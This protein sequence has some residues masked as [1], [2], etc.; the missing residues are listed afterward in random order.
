MSRLAGVTARLRDPLPDEDPPTLTRYPAWARPIQAVFDFMG[1]KAG[2]RE[3]DAGHLII[4]FF[5]VFSALLINDGGYGLL[6]LTGLLLAYRPLTRAGGA[7]IVNLGLYVAAATALFGSVTGAFFGLQFNSL[8]SFDFIKFDTQDM[9]KISFALGIAHL[10]LGRG[11]AVFRQFPNT[12]ALGEAGWLAIIWGVYLAIVNV[13]TASPVPAVAMPLIAAGAASVVAFSYNEKGRFFRNRLFGLGMLAGNAT[14]VFSDVMSYI[15]L[16]A[17]GFAS[18]SLAM[19]TNTI[20]EQIG[21]PVFGVPILI[22][23]HTINLGLGLI[24][25]FVHGLRL[26]TLEFSRQMGVQW[27]GR[28]FVPLTRIQLKTENG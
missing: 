28:A 12:R 7:N 19:T 10:T 4:I 1:Y 2:Y 17:V 22:I 20:A 3:Y 13:F 14:T 11:L 25:L 8:G 21:N 16:M 15:R 6:M 5:T 27:T 18:M 9:I 24:A 23:G 26:N